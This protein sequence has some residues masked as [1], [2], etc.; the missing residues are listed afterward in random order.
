MSHGG[1]TV[2]F[3]ARWCGCLAGWIVRG[4]DIS[5]LIVN[6]KKKSNERW[7]VCSVISSGR[8]DRRD[9]HLLPAAE[10]GAGLFL[11]LFIL[12]YVVVVLQ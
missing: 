11:Q 8:V 12:Q 7:F 1:E 6:T 5:D 4:D 10:I 3:H 2:D 9:P